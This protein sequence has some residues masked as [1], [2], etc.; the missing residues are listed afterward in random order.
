M[1]ADTGLRVVIDTNVWIS[2]FLTGKGAPAL[3]VRHVLEQG[4]PVFSAATFSELEARL[5]LPKF[6]RYVSMDNRKALLHDVEALAY[7]TEVP[8]E[9]EAQTF[10]R[11]PDD[12]KFIQAA[13]AA[14]APWL[15]TG[16][17]D[18][19]AVPKLSGLRIL[20]PTMALQLLE[21]GR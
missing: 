5:W 2:A 13:M 14:K 16:D 6:D 1:K 12:D 11:D 9:I 7:W 3:L 15:L 10:C 20:S 17:Q 8:A 21:A 4:R 18:L 19:L